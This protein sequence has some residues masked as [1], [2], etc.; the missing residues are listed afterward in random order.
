VEDEDAVGVLPVK[1]PARRF[2][3]LSIAP[4]SKLGR[5]RSAAG[6]VDELINVL[7]DTPNQGA[8]CIRIL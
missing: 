7:K 3:N 6:M 4:S 2:D 8:R 1:D 5:L